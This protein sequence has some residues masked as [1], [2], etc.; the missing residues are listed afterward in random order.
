MPPAVS[1]LVYKPDTQSTDEFIMIIADPSA[2][3]K[4]KDGDTTIPIVDIVDS[5]A[6]F[7][8]GTGTQGTLGQCSKQQ[9]DTIFNTHNEDEVAQI[10]LEKGTLHGSDTVGFK[11]YTDT[12]KGQGPNVDVRGS[13]SNAFR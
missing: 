9:L 5:Y 12:N 11:K 2:L 8:S 1:K 10:M 3:K 13:G 7:H 6:V 4:W